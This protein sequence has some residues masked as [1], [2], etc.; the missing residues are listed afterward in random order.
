MQSETKVVQ[1][2]TNNEQDINEITSQNA[3]SI[4]SEQMG[5]DKV[6]SIDKD[7][8]DLERQLTEAAVE[9]VEHKKFGEKDSEEF[10]EG[11]YGWIVLIGTFFIL[12]IT[13]GM[14]NTFGVYQI[15]YQE[16]YSDIKP[17]VIALIGSLQPTMIY[18][19]SIP[20]IWLHNTVGVR[21]TVLIGG[22]IMVFSLMMISICKSLWQAFLAQGVLYGFG[23]GISFFTAMAVPPQWFKERRAL[24]VG[25]TASGSS[26]GG[27]I[28][29]IVFQRLVKEVGFGWANRIIGFILLPLVLLS[30]YCIKARFPRVKQQ[31]MPYWGVCKDWRFMFLTVACAIGF[32]GLFPPLFYITEYSVRLGDINSNVSNYILAILNACSIVGRIVPPYIGDKIGRLNIIIPAVILTGVL[33]FALWYPSKGEGL[34]VSF[35]VIWGIASGSFIAVFPASIGQLFGIKHFSSRL[36]VMFLLSAPATLVGPSVTGLWIPN[37]ADNVEGFSKV[38]IFSGTMM[39]ACGVLCLILRLTYSRNLAIFI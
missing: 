35:A 10:P 3:S 33:Q 29:P 36:T 26:L 34:V 38:I 27:V 19:S 1:K 16:R 15:Y 2:V 23:A 5:L 13:Y 24:A 9:K 32:F 20:V 22:L 39:L 17:S 31:I 7:K 25:I 18:L 30:T 6:D 28:W 21:I 12:N 4:L 8:H 11:G 37:S 14:V